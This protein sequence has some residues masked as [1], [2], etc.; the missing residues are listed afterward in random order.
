[1]ATFEEGKTA[2]QIIAD[3]IVN[4]HNETIKLLD[5]LKRVN[6]ENAQLTSTMNVVAKV[7]LYG[8]V[9]IGAAL[10]WHWRKSVSSK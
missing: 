4:N 1:M 7:A 9:G 3:L 5:E 8:S 10:L 2:A 6:E